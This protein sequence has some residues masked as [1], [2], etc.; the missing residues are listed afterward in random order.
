VLGPVRA[1]AGR[2]LALL[3]FLTFSIGF[4]TGPA[5]TYLFLYSER[6][7][8]MSTG[9]TAAML[10]AA[11]PVGLAGLLVGRALADRVGRRP[12][13]GG[14]QVLI[15]GAAALAYSGTS[16]AVVCGY[17]LAILAASAYGPAAGAQ[18]TELFPTSVRGSVAGWLAAA[19]VAGAVAGLV[20][21]G[22]LA[23]RLGSFG[24]AAVTLSIPVALA[25]LLFALLPE[26]RGME[27]EQSAPEPRDRAPAAP[28]AAAPP[29]AQARGAGLP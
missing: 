28:D 1:G 3:G 5:N 12:T 9:S 11:G 18:A 2:T 26:T 21:F 10:L 19:G 27:P 24:A 13:A 17:L 7:L 8:G 25:A 23:D 16:A 6:V 4:A 15:A 20:T 14:A 22:A 29:G